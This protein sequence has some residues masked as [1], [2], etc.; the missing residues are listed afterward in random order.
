MEGGESDFQAVLFWLRGFLMVMDSLPTPVETAPM[1]CPETQPTFCP[2]TQITEGLEMGRGEE[3]YHFY[4][5][6]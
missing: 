5:C 2:E 6:N 1:P 4:L 3:G